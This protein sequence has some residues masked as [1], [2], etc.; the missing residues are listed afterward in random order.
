[1]TKAVSHPK[2]RGKTMPCDHCAIDKQLGYDHCP[3][4]CS[5][6]PATMAVTP[7]VLFLDVADQ[8]AH[9]LLV[10]AAI[11]AYAVTVWL[12]MVNRARA[13]L[14]KEVLAL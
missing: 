11:P 12:A 10:S 8:I 4:C 6:T 14:T 2:R 13:F 5:E 9:Q 7:Q 3:A 1:M